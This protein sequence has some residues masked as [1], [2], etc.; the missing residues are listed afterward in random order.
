ML[1]EV[2]R[3]LRTDLRPYDIVG[4]YGGEE[5]LLILPGC[6]LTSGSR[7]AEEIRKIVCGSAIKT[8]YGTSSVTISAG[9]TASTTGKQRSAA[10]L[11]READLS[12][13]AAKN[14]GR[15]RVEVFAAARSASAG[16]H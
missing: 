14:N 6:S 11:L 16:Q 4:R 7:R 1:K 10:E 12:L 15:N 2:A 3:R 8:P 9:V 5:F 13:Y